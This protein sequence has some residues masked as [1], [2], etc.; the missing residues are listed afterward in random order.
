[1]QKLIIFIIIIFG[2]FHAEASH[3]VGGEITY[4]C[5][6]NNQ[7]R[8][9][10][11]I[12][13]DC[14]PTNQGGGNPQAL[15]SD[16]PAYISIFNGNGSFFSFDSLFANSAGGSIVPLEFNNSC[17]NNV[18]TKCLNRMQFVLTKTLPPNATGY[19]VVLQRCCRNQATQNIL[20][21]GATGASFYC[22]V[23][24][25]NVNCNNSAVFK[26]S[27]PQ[28]VC[29]NNPFLFDNSATDIDGDS[30]SYEFCSAEIGADQNDPK[31]INTADPPPYAPVN[32][33]SPYTPTMPIASNPIIAINPVT[34]II[35]GTPTLQGIFSI[36]V[37]CKEWRN[38]VLINTIRRDFQVDITNCSKA[39]VADIP[40]RSQEP[41]TYIINCKNFSVNFENNSRGGFSYAWDFG[42]PGITTDVSTTQNP[43]YTYPDTGTYVV[44]L[45]VNP[46]ST[47]P[48]S[49]ERLVKIYPLFTADFN[50]DGQ[51]C[52]G[53]PIS[54]SDNSNT[55]YFNVSYW[56]WNF[57]DGTTSSAQNPNHTFPNIGKDFRVMLESGNSAGCRD[58][59]SRTVP[60]GFVNLDAGNDTVVLKNELVQFNATGTETYNW[61]PNSFLN[62]STISNPIA[63]YP[64]TGRYTY[65]VTG[66]TADGCPDIDTINVLVSDQAYLVLPNA[67]SPNG[68]GNNDIFRLLA[69][70]FKKINH[71]RIFNR[72]GQKVFEA[73]DYYSGW[74]GKFKGIDQPMSTYFWTVSAI[75][76]R[77]SDQIFRGDVILIR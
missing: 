71:F 72:W 23:P 19:D 75:D 73:N 41:N 35:T 4:V 36:T 8:F 65:I 27:P 52:P 6:G 63:L 1:M 69:S 58:T 28:I 5:L 24:P 34:G 7:Y 48:D 2:C 64:D 17:V 9:T 51:L 55:T 60:I 62:N 45:V 56:L 22:T 18:P 26:N 3:I 54:F 14:R 11:N 29:I 47:C 50:F 21:G 53:T 12:Y 16:N 66:A 74:D 33:R 43:T 31:P 44:K 70:G 38:G 40:V 39:V 10:I 61:S 57:D 37:C 68:D 49:I 15:T 67:F 42:V 59:A 76:L 25:S 13:R 30:L 46:N 32:Y 77:D 20:N